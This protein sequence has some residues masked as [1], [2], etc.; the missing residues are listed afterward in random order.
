MKKYETFFDG[1]LGTWKISPVG[2]KLKYGVKTSMFM[3]LT[4]TES[5]CIDVK[6]VELIEQL[7][8]FEWEN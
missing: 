5:T 6:K 4:C 2:F 1:S 7:G 3:H 8:V